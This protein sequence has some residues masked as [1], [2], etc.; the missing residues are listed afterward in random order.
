MCIIEIMYLFIIILIF[1][2]ST[3]ITIINIFYIKL[4][5]KQYLRPPAVNKKQE[6]VNSWE[7]NCKLQS[8]RQPAAKSLR[9]CRCRNGATALDYPPPVCC[10]MGLPS[11]KNHRFPPRA[12]GGTPDPSPSRTATCIQ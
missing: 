1:F 8:R 9:A 6:F 3:T 11:S 12:G 7:P 10:C 4:I 2:F 5:T